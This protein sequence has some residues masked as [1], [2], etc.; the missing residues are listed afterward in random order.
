[1]AV[2]EM[3]PA[4]TAIER[5]VLRWM[6]DRLGFPGSADGVL[7]SGGSAG[8][9]TA[10]LAARQ[11]KAGF[12]AWEEGVYG[13]PPLAILTSDAAHYSVARAARRMNSTEPRLSR[14]PSVADGVVNRVLLTR[15]LG[16][17]VGGVGAIEQDAG[18][19][20]VI[21]VDDQGRFL[22]RLLN[23]SPLN[24][25][26]PSRIAS[27]SLPSRSWCASR[28]CCSSVNARRGN[29]FSTRTDR[30]WMT[31]PEEPPFIHSW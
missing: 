30:C 27:A 20:N 24:A 1:M 7:T 22:V 10:L 14:P 25:L 15:M 18:C 5:S 16:S 21:D 31:L 12:D 17:G 9:L 13:G 19:L 23:H 2:F 6:G 28:R 8:N 3:G 11:R 4:A 26:K 29:C